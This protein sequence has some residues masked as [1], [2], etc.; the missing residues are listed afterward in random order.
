MNSFYTNY[1][2]KQLGL[3]KFGENVLISK[4]CS[5]YNPEKL[6][7]GNNVRIDD[8]SILSGEITIGNYVHISAFCG[9]YGRF[10][11]EIGNFCGL[12]PRCT[13][14][15]ASDDFSGEFMISPMV[16]FELTNLK[17]G[18]V[19]LE[20]YVQIGIN[21]TIMPNIT[22]EKGSASGAYTFINKNMEAFYIYKGIPCEKLKK[23]SENLVEISRG[24]L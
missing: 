14:L 23:R 24:L 4:K 5:I 12:S 22:C 17:K 8:F 16:P 7:L 15:S 21:S 1:E 2:L 9:L 11:I 20:D 10:K 3:K 18:K 19:T 13:I 6:I